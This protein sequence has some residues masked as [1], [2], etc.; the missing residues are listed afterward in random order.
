M[1]LKDFTRVSDY[2]WLLPINK[3]NGMVVPVR[4]FASHR[5]LLN[6]MQDRSIEQAVNAAS[7]PGLV[8]EVKVMPDMHQDYGF[9]IGGVAASAYP[10]GVIS[11]GGI[12]YDINCGVRLLS[13]RIPYAEV[14][15]Y[16]P[17]LADALNRCCPSGVGKKS[18]LSLTKSDLFQVL[19]QGAK[20]LRKKGM[21]E[22]SDLLRAEHGGS[23]T[24]ADP[25]FVS[26]RALERGREQLGSL[27]S[28]N[29]FLEIGVVDQV[30]HTD[31]ALQMG[32]QEGMLTLMIHS[33]SR[34]LGHQVCT[35]YVQQFQAVVQRYGIHL[36]D[37]EL[38][39]APLESKE[40]QAYFA[41]MK[42]AANFAYA[43][44]QTL[45]YYARGAFEEALVGKV[46]DW[47]LRAVYDVSHNIAHIET[48]R[49]NG[50]SRKVCVHRKGATRAF[51]PGDA[52]LP[53]EYR[54]FGQPV[55]VP[56][57]MGT[58]SWVLVGTE[59]SMEKSLGS[60]CHGAGRLL[61]RHEALKVV[62]GENL[63]Q[64]LT[65]RGIHV[66]ASSVKGLAEEAPQAYKDVD[67]V[68]ESVA[69]AGIA[70]KAVR[71]R[72]VVVIKG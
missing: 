28:G 1:D 20:W 49:I 43:N 30:F 65:Q 57:S 34:G 24:G 36:A 15:D 63:R 33:G 27:G 25:Q 3:Q 26:E 40:G 5:M 41:A 61:S 14:I 22:E 54:Q 52:A 18:N 16:L 59:K 42:A 29:H 53:P 2:E 66:R 17:A 39:C 44:R 56:G 48:H 13:T 4:L 58:S 46:N 67:E 31:A 71:I 9:P 62:R 23:L 68:I 10:D 38:V 19:E 72:P 55:L 12:G 60:C 45:A 21:A 70:Q 11:P 37:R 50:Q 6:A 32:L 47:N 35:D 8:D 51:G 64:E 7:L 69:G